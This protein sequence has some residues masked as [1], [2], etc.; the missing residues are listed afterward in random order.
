MSFGWS[1][2]DVAL[3]V[4]L[5][6]NTAQGARAACGQYDELTRETGSL[7]TILNRLHL[8]VAKPESSINRHEPYGR[9][10]KSIATGCEEV[11][12]QLNKILVKY[13]ALSEQERSVRR[14]WKKIR[15]GNGAVADVA[16][17]RSR[18]TY[19]TSALSL[20]LNLVSVGT[21][22][23]VEKKMDQAGGD[24]R[25]IK[26]AVNHIT[27][28]FLATDRRERSVLTAYTNDDR[29]A[30]REL[31]RGLVKAGFR[32]SVVRKHMDTIMGYVKELG[33]KGV[34]DDI[35][36]EE[37]GSVTAMANRLGKPEECSDSH[38]MA[39][40]SFTTTSSAALEA[41]V[42][43]HGDH[44][45][46][47]PET[48]GKAQASPPTVPH[49]RIESP[50]TLETDPD[51]LSND[52]Q[53]P[54]LSE[55]FSSN[56]TTPEDCQSDRSDSQIF[57]PALQ[58][59]KQNLRESRLD[60]DATILKLESLRYYSCTALGAPS[61]TDL[62]FLDDMK[63]PDFIADHKVIFRTR[64]PIH[65]AHP[66]RLSGLLQSFHV[67]VMSMVDPNCLIEPARDPSMAWTRFFLKQQAVELLLR[68]RRTQNAKVID[69]QYIRRLDFR[70]VT[71]LFSMFAVDCIDPRSTPMAKVDDLMNRIYKW[72]FEFDS[73][74]PE[75]R[76]QLV[77]Y[78]SK[79]LLY[80]LT[81]HVRRDYEKVIPFAGDVRRTPT[82]NSHRRW[83][84]HPNM[85]VGN[86][87]YPWIDGSAEKYPWWTP[88][89]NMDALGSWGDGAYTSKNYLSSLTA[90]ISVLKDRG[91][92]PEAI[93]DYLEE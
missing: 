26:A 7:H 41:H 10:L 6:Y 34:L 12:N 85:K 51:L 67:R 64:Q 45:E 90:W 28:H 31:R 91:L 30:W 16:E 68:S 56:T 74:L 35:N 69:L 62:I 19:Y 77:K 54:D 3:L 13:N 42:T 88:F 23:A 36:I 55:N 11:L 92:T 89:R 52:R 33:D 86:R 5:A 53:S 46:H 50:G 75:H 39:G 71:T 29:D 70:Q 58:P 32:D 61:R 49:S 63:L 84:P 25:D 18:V 59:S 83:Y 93:K 15:F 21:I 37:A 8:E 82:F 65:S 47:P 27:A 2:S 78:Y 60:E 38:N 43:E 17:L 57:P 22:G 72:E 24:L 76:E 1:A 66:M 87:P 73:K 9:E 44:E 80:K 81:W 79:D 20:F 14:L 40:S 4:K 48:D